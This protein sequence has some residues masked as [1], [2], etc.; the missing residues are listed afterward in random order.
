MTKYS[1]AY[2]LFKTKMG[3]EDAF[4]TRLDDLGL[5]YHDCYKV[6][7]SG[8]NIMIELLHSDWQELD[9]FM[10]SLQDDA[11]LKRCIIDEMRMISH[12]KD[13]ERLSKD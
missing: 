1:K 9:E 11:E 4:L 2:I 7:G 10:Y 5:Q 13:I 8:Y 6:F 12:D 3:T